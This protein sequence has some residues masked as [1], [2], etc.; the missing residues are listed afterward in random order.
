MRAKEYKEQ[1]HSMRRDMHRATRK[2]KP[3]KVSAPTLLRK[4]ISRLPGSAYA[5]TASTAVC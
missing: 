5:P 2:R 4:G 3:N 1:L